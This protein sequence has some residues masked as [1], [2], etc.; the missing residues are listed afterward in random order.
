MN[1]IR[2]YERFSSAA[3]N[4][5]IGPKTSAYLRNLA[6]R[7]HANGVQAMVRIMQSNGGI[8]T[9]ENASELPIGLLLSGPAGGVIGG[10]WTGKHCGKENIIT[11]DIGGTSAD[12]SVIERGELRVKNPRDTEVAGLPVLV[13]MIDVD[14]IGAGGGS[15]AYVDPGGAFRV[16]PRSAG[17]DPG[18]ACYAKGGEEPTVTDAQVVLG[19]MDPEHFLGGD[20]AI[21]PSLSSKAIE[22]HIAK[23]LGVSVEQAAL[24]ILKIVNNN[25]ALAINAN[26]V[27][28][29]VDPR[30]FTLMGFG[31]AGPLHSV[32]L[33]EAIYAKDVISP[34][35]PGI[36]AATGT[37]S[38]RP[39]I[40][41]HAFHSHGHRQSE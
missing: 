8:S 27:A 41:I 6:S 1:T 2:E 38:H 17:A 22:K 20:L 25:M 18:P 5:Y 14:A 36:T 34:V 12:I 35:H 3:M 10:R 11:I 26:S 28:K 19:R 23:P 32:S 16:G 31:G 40:R 24:G 37:L 39:T 29:G 4:G 9:V 30:N 15:I 21:D 33:A 7:L 13:P